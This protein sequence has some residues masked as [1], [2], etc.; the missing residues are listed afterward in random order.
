MK[1]THLYH[2]G[3]CVEMEHSICIFD[4]YKG[5]LPELDRTK[6]L[7]VFASHFHPDHYD[8]QIWKLADKYPQVDYILDRNIKVRRVPQ[9]AQE[10][11]C[12]VRS[13]QHY[14]VGDCQIDTLLSTDTG[15][16]FAVTAEG[17]TLYHAGDLNPWRWDGE[18]EAD[19]KWQL[20]TYKA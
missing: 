2:S 10:H 4:W 18:P 20:G 12:F 19:N 11:I 6:H 16:A 15:V 8:P 14:D 3:F 9:A 17:I 5:K 1:I 13:D 7:Y